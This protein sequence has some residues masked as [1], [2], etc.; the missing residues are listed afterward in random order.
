[1]SFGRTWVLALVWLPFA[2]A[3]YERSRARRLGALVLKTATFALILFALS[4]PNLELSRSR[5]ALAVLVDTSASVSPADLERASRTVKGDGQREGFQLPSHHS[6]RPG[7]ARAR[8]GE[9]DSLSPGRLRATAGPG[10]HAT[11]LEAAIREAAASLPSDMLPRIALITGGRENQ[12]SVARAAWQAQQ[13][14]VPIDTF[15]MQ[16]RPEPALSLESVFVPGNAFT[17]E[18]IAIDL[19]VSSPTAAQVE[20]ELTAEGRSLGKS[21]VALAAGVNPVRMHANLNTPGSGAGSSRSRFARSKACSSG[22][23]RY[24]QAVMLKRP[25][26]LYVSQDPESIDAHL[27]G[28]LQSAQ[29][30]VTRITW[31]ST[32]CQ[33]DSPT[34]K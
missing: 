25:K 24:D 29:F 13:A 12:G 26:L 8:I 22:E 14:G 31:A 1:M 21:Q 15:A 7:Y 2:W 10:A 16:G 32:T 17:G 18:P 23:L 20:I 27:T 6:L 3:W 34:T 19:S 4:E 11:D 33:P 9:A 28:A 30:D 5:V